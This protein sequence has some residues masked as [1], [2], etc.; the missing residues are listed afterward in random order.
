M[1]G[2]TVS[3]YRIVDEIGGGGMGD[4]GWAKAAPLHAELSRRF[5]LAV[6]PGQS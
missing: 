4:R 1:I 2:T 6:G 3:H 5:K